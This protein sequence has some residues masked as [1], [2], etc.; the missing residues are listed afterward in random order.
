MHVAREISG[1][2]SKFLELENHSASPEKTL[3][4]KKST[5]AKI[6]RSDELSSWKMG[7]VS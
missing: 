7:E 6:K 3:K 2:L 5:G 1:D 4:N